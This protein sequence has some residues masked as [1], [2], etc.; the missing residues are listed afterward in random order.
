[1]I[2]TDPLPVTM[3]WS[4][5]SKRWNFKDGPSAKGGKKNLW[6]AGVIQLASSA[7]DFSA[8]FET[9][10]AQHIVPKKVLG[11]SNF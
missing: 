6:A 9:C 7:V 5:A 1:M 8:T 3:T 2:T 4:V 10:A 11:P